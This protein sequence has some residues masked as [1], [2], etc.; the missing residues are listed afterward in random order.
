MQDEG[1]AQSP[2]PYAA[3][4]KNGVTR[5]TANERGA[6]SGEEGGMG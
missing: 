4:H 1:D 5:N 3:E 2:S 6:E